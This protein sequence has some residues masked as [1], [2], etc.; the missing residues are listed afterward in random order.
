MPRARAHTSMLPLPEL[1]EGRPSARMIQVQN[2]RRATFFEM[3]RLQA[4]S[5]SSISRR[6]SL[7][8]AAASNALLAPSSELCA[9]C[10][11]TSTDVEQ[12]SF[13]A[14]SR[15]AA[16]P[17][18]APP[19]HARC[20]NGSFSPELKSSCVRAGSCMSG[21]TRS[22]AAVGGDGGKSGYDSSTA[23]STQRL[24]GTPV[25]SSESERSSSMTT[26][27]PYECPTKTM[28]P[29][30]VADALHTA[31]RK[32]AALRVSCAGAVPRQL[33][34]STTE[35][36]PSSVSRMDGSTRPDAPH[37]TTKHTRGGAMAVTQALV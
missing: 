24:G 4:R 6:K 15:N 14:R 22:V 1:F 34:T 31:S 36:R 5:N 26:R 13:A 32:R 2:W 9:A 20:R 23:R 17:D 35:P 33:S 29:R 12:C 28:S 7:C 27:Q 3:A 16:P 11:V 18:G 21:G 30:S 19:R 25:E 8:A 10:A 37:A